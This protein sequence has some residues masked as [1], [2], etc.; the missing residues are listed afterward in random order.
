MFQEAM[1]TEKR[2]TALAILL[3]GRL[4]SEDTTDYWSGQAKARIAF[5]KAVAVE[6]EV[7]SKILGRWEWHWMGTNWGDIEVRKEGVLERAVEITQDSRII[8]YENDSIVRQEQFD[9][10]ADRVPGIREFHLHLVPSNELLRVHYSPTKLILTEPNCA[11]GCLTNEY[12]RKWQ[13]NS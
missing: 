6:R 13:K 11:C 8:F 10:K 1:D 2:D 12:W 5:M 4:A 7:F 3:Y 9:L